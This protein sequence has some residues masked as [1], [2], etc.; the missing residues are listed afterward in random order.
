VVPAAAEAVGVARRSCA[1]QAGAALDDLVTL[2]PGADWVRRLHQNDPTT[3]R[4]R[5]PVLIVQGEDDELLPLGDAVMA[6]RRLCGLDSTVRL[7]RLEATDHGT[8]IDRSI[9]EV[10]RWLD[11][12]LAGDRLHGCAQRRL[13]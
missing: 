5:V 3:K 10:V 11:H 13:A 9:S 8:V 6:Y 1:L 12:R 4:L 2:A 7:Q